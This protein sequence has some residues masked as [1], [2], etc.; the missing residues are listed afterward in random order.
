MNE[1]DARSILAWQ[2][3]PPYDFYN[4]SGTLEEV[5]TLIAPHNAYY[6]IVSEQNSLIAFCCY[7]QEAQVPGGD[8][9]TKALGVGFG[10]R[11]DLTGQRLG[12]AIVNACLT[13]A[14]AQFAPTAFRV[15]V[16]AFNLRALNLWRKAGFDAVQ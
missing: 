9:L 14:R 4:A 7:G 3:E 15:T 6:A 10:L 8:Y 12:L 11:P 16:A 1:A 5:Q 13:F 2:Y